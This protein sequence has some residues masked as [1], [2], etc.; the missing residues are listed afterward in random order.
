MLFRSQEVASFSPALAA[1]E[2]WLV[3]NKADLLDA[4]EIESQKRDIMEALDWQGP[5]YVISA[6]ARTGLD[7]LCQDLMVFLEERRQAEEDDPALA[8]A[9]RASQEAMQ[10]EARARI[11]ALRAAQRGA[12]RLS[13]DSDEDDMDWEYAP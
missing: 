9:E 2:R 13:V 4:G 11:E 7:V 12:A 10:R 5:C 3:L 6:V 1:R 8:E